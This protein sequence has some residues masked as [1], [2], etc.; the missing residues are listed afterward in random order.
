MRTR[1]IDFGNFKARQ[2]A[3][4]IVTDIDIENICISLDSEMTKMY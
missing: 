2:D 4:V 1:K 3:I